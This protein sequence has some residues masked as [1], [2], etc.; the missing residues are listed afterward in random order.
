MEKKSLE[1]PI[2]S[3]YNMNY[4]VH[5]NPLSIKQGSLFCLSHW[6]LPNH[7]VSHCALG[8][9]ENLSMSRNIISLGSLYHDAS[10]HAL[11]IF[12]SSQWA[13]VSSHIGPYIGNE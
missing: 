12:E 13:E 7:N 2:I 4:W 9:F 8:I 6:D 5:I 3:I 10:H 11:G 1:S